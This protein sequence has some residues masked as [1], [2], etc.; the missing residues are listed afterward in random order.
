MLKNAKRRL[1][2]PAAPD[3]GCEPLESRR[4]LSA[5]LDLTLTP[6]ITMS[7]LAGGSS[8]T[9]Y[10]PAQIAH[11]YGFDQV[12]F[13]GVKGDGAGQTI[14]IVDAYRD[15]NVASDLAKF[16]AQFGLAAPPSLKVVN[17]SGGSANSVAV[18]AGWSGEIALDVEWA[19]AVAP[20]ANILL[21][22]TNSASLGDL[23][24]GVNYARNAA[25]VSVVSMSW[26]GGEFSSQS[27]YDSYFTTPKGHT[28]VTFV[29]AA[30]DSGSWYGPEWPSSSPNVLAVGGTS[31]TVSNTLGTYSSETGWSDGGGGIS[32]YVPEPSYQKSAQGTGARTTPDVSYNADPNTGF[33]VYDSVPYQGQS[34]WFV[35]GGTSAGSPQWGALV[36]IA[37]QGRAL[38]GKGTLD[39]ATGTLPTLY[40]LYHA[41]GTSSYTA[42]A[43]DFHDVTTGATSWYYGAAPGYDAVAGLGSPKA[44]QVVA[45]L[46]GTGTSTATTLAGTTTTSGSTAT[47]APHTHHHHHATVPA[48]ERAAADVAGVLTAAAGPMLSGVRSVVGGQRTDHGTLTTDHYVFSTVR[49]DGAVARTTLA[50]IGLPTGT[51]SA[52][53]R[54]VSVDS[55][56]SLATQ[57][58]AGLPSQEQVASAV[59]NVAE[60]MLSPRQWITFAHL[61]ADAFSDAVAAFSDESAGLATS[62]VQPNFSRAGAITLGVAAVDAVLVGYWFAQRGRRKHQAVAPVDVSGRVIAEI[63]TPEE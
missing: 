40:S 14:A 26:G 31:L 19:H 3:R 10:T 58:W 54:A 62:V 61:N 49:V 35:I 57:F 29:A 7:P 22:E 55:A 23:L 18:D 4:L 48:D 43:A 51:V 42:Y 37:N 63:V 41:P 45:S 47:A 12:S 36:A 8:Y 39:G 9:A 28:G 5:A 17:Q 44:P 60:A 15:P 46:M 59:V 11:A 27:A 16:D 24:A 6:N 20:K 33:F 21:V 32:S 50:A 30:G 53:S 56:P 52:V 34:G 13:N 25:G 2:K 38:A 1:L